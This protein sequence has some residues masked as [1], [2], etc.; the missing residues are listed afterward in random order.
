MTQRPPFVILNDVCWSCGKIHKV[1]VKNQ[2]KYVLGV[3]RVCSKCF[4]QNPNY[5]K[6]RVGNFPVMTHKDWDEF[7]KERIRGLSLSQQNKN[8]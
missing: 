6:E 3:E 4:M 8:D 2:R 1:L 7:Y 5:L